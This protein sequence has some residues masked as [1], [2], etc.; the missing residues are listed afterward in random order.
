MPATVFNFDD[1]VIETSEEH[2]LRLARERLEELNALQ[3]DNTTRHAELFERFKS[4]SSNEAKIKLKSEEVIPL[5]ESIDKANAEIADLEKKIAALTGQKVSSSFSFI[6]L[7][8]I[9]NSSPRRLRGRSQL[10]FARFRAPLRRRS[11]PRT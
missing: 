1:F 3:T 6:I 11:P 2:E 8:L 4:L 10:R 7:K 5:K 9:F